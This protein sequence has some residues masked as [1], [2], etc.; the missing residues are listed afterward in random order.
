MNIVL[1]LLSFKVYF[2][3]WSCDVRHNDDSIYNIASPLFYFLVDNPASGS[4]ILNTK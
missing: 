1:V 3:T 2:D 4:K